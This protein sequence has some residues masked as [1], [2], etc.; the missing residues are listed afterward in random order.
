MDTDIAAAA[1]QFA[2]EKIKVQDYRNALSA[3]Q[4]RADQQLALQQGFVTWLQAEYAK[5]P[6]DPDPTAALRE[7]VALTIADKYFTTSTAVD[8]AAIAAD[9]EK[10]AARWAAAVKVAMQVLNGATA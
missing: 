9:A 2:L 5:L 1:D 7:K 4:T 8:P 10:D 6:T 3:Q